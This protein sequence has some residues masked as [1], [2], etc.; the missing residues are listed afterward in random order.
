MKEIRILIED[1]RLT[2]ER[3]QQWVKEA[4]QSLGLKMMV[5]NIDKESD[6]HLIAVIGTLANGKITVV[7]KEE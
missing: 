4:K 1:D 7:S 6:A 3:F 2:T 5:G